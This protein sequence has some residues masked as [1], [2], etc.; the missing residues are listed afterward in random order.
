LTRIIS[1]TA[2]VNL[3]RI[4]KSTVTAMLTPQSPEYNFLTNLDES[5]WDVMS[6]N[7]HNREVCIV[8][9]N[10]AGNKLISVVLPN[11]KP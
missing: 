9:Y 7:P 11:I 8:I 4:G 10:P 3:Q 1:R 6:F 5:Q 2:C